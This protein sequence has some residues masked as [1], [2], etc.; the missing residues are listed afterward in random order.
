MSTVYDVVCGM[1]TEKG[2]W[3]SQSEYNGKTYYFAVMGARTHLRNRQS[4]I[5]KI[6]PRS[7]PALI[8]HHRASRLTRRPIT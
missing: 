3:T 5:W 8:P 4:T 2:N 1:S 7:T 6:S